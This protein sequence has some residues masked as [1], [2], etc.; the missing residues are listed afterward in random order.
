VLAVTSLG[1]A[2]LS[3]PRSGPNR[4]R[5]VAIWKD[6]FDAAKEIELPDGA[7]GLAV[8]L[9]VKERKEYSADGR[10]RSAVS[11]S[12]VLAG[13]HPVFVSP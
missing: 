2:K 1:M 9:S 5:V 8:T 13:V 11:A 12:V 6:A 3:R 10:V 7:Q 4:C